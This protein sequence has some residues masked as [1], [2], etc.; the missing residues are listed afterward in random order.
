MD[1]DREYFLTAYALNF[2]SEDTGS[3]PCRDAGYAEL[4][5]SVFSST[6]ACEHWNSVFKEATTGFFEFLTYPPSTF[7]RVCIT[8]AVKAMPKN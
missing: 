5:S 6:S 3:N 1:A 8:Y 4:V 7:I 2:Y